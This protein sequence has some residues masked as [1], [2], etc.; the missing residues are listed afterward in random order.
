MQIPD[1]EKPPL[2]RSWKGWYLLVAGVLL[3]LII[4]F[5]LFTKNFQ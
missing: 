4:F 3:G 5:Y 2:F 1:P